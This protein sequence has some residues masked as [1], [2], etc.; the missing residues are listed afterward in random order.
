MTD[1][2]PM[3]P[4]ASLPA[5]LTS[6]IGRER[7]IAQIGELLRGE[8][9][10]ITLTGPG[11]VG[12]T[13]LALRVGHTVRDAFADG[14]AF[15]PLAPITDPELVG[16]AIMQ[17]LLL[18]DRSDGASA[19]ALAELLRQRRLLLILDNYE[20]V[21]AAAPLLADLLATCP[22]LRLL[23]TSRILLRV[24]SEREVPIR[25][26]PLPDA[27]TPG[28]TDAIRLFVARAQ[29]A[30][31][32]FTL[33]AANAPAVNA[34][35][36]RLD[37]LPLALE[38]VAARVRALPPQALLP[39]LARALPLLTQGR[40][41]DPERLQ[42]MRNAIA[43]SHHLLSPPDQ[44]L[45]H[46][47]AI[48]AGGFTLD[49]A[50]AV[51][52]DAEAPSDADDVVAGVM[53]LAEQSLIHR[54]EPVS[55]HADPNEPRFGMLETVREFGLEQ[56][57]VHDDIGAVRERHAAYFLQF[58]EATAPD[59]SGSGQPAALARLDA[60][61]ANVRAALHW[62]LDHQRAEPA[63]RL[64]SALTM[65]W[66]MRG[67]HAEGSALLGAAQAL[68]G[69]MS[70]ALRARALTRSS[71]L[72]DWDGDYPRAVATG[73]AAVAIWRE[74]GDPAGLADAL[75]ALGLALTQVDPPRAEA[76][77]RECLELERP[78]GNVLLLADTLES[79]AISI[80]ARG[81]YAAAVTLME[82]AVP[83]ARA[84]GDP[85]TLAGALGDLGHVSMVLGLD[86]Q[87]RQAL[88]ESLAHF[89]DLEHVQW[90]VW[91][92]ASLGGVA[93]GAQPDRAVRL[94]AAG[95]RMQAAAGETFRP[96]VQPN[97]DRKLA[98]AR[99]TLGETAFAGAWA[100]GQALSLDEAIAE[101]FL[102]V[103]G[104]AIPAE[105]DAAAAFGLS[106]R[107][108]EVLRLVAAGHA[109]PEIAARLFIS[110][111][112]VKRHVSTILGKLDL[113]SRPAAVAFAHTHGLT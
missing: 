93:A 84:S 30:D 59:V 22:D 92:L 64:A 66:Y 47:L 98:Q 1:L 44:A 86:V 60:D 52:G 40:R 25:P 85:H 111:P 7:E 61:Q 91:C 15:V 74:L 112:T 62:F 106:P 99:A 31:A 88:G 73:D 95:A 26:L 20:Q 34:I 65:Y 9:R 76:I 8:D 105:P 18:Q 51:A 45:F 107:E 2:L 23:V 11:G 109:N 50:A 89:R 101:A 39:R 46:R 100:A 19:A 104:E 102:V 48:F 75:R 29:A 103:N 33:T 49:A 80:Y 21:V 78:L 24:S 32:T 17:A 113:P 82:E 79:L 63:V 4:L 69:A 14:V 72:A 6:F 108:A 56:L 83:L 97:Y 67:A 53:S 54:V 90:I 43:W 68:P 70:P 71:S 38:L 13:R 87:A 36:Q 58:A 55:K 10:L 3:P 77:L 28:E 27:A 57:A 5:P 12:K 16:P 35:C 96:F 37:G 94:F 81:D 42:T 41:D 110:V